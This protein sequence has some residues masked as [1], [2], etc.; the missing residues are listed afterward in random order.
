MEQQGRAGSSTGGALAAVSG[1]EFP[2]QIPGSEAEA[3]P[4]IAGEGSA[5]G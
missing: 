5:G 4:G 2:S 3:L 1:Q